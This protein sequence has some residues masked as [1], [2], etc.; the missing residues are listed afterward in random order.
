MLIEK[1]KS[2]MGQV[3]IFLGKKPNKAQ[4]FHMKASRKQA[5]PLQKES[6]ASPNQAKIWSLSLK[7]QLISLETISSCDR[8]QGSLPGAPS[9]GL[10]CRKVQPLLYSPGRGS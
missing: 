3:F 5:Y 10:R 8:E 9:P 6:G 4:A 7:K 1:K 2:Q